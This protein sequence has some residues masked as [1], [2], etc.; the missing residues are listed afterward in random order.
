MSECRWPLAGALLV[1][2]ATAGAAADP[3][4]ARQRELLYLLTQDCGSCH[5]LTL[6]GGLGP[7]LTRDALA[8][9]APAMLQAVILHG[10]PGTPMPPWN[11]FMTDAEAAWLVEQLRAGVPDAR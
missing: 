1:L 11:G 7:A 10:R 2:A 4:P 8:G 3:A 6:K 9:K 5:G